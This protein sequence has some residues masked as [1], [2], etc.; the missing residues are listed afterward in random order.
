MLTFLLSV[1]APSVL[2]ASP[3]DANVTLRTSCPQ[4][5]LLTFTLTMASSLPHI[6]WRYKGGLMDGPCTLWRR[7]RQQGRLEATSIRTLLTF[8]QTVPPP[9]SQQEDLC[10]NGTF[11][12][13]YIP[14][15]L[16]SIVHTA[17][18]VD[19]NVDCGPKLIRRI[20]CIHQWIVGS[21][22]GGGSS[23]S[24]NELPWIRESDGQPLC[25]PAVVV[26]CSQRHPG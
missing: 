17:S 6:Q 8:S 15:M 18:P 23:S 2:T 10:V 19:D 16:S 5:P 14:A 20:V 11:R 22:L 4:W 13:A 26:I 9:V 7:T 1:G 24:H 21:V 12:P 25:I 3:A